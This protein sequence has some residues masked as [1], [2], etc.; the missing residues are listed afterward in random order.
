MIE[1]RCGED[2]TGRMF[3]W[4]TVLA[5]DTSGAGRARWVCRCKCG[6][7]K[8][9][10]AKDMK[11]GKTKSCGCWIRANNP[12]RTHGHSHTRLYSI[13]QGMMRRCHDETNAGYGDYG[14]RGIAV[15]E[16][17]HDV[18]NFHAD[19]GAPPPKHE[20]ERLDNDKGYSPENCKWATRKEQLRN[21]R[22]NLIVEF[23]GQRKCVTDW[24]GGD[25]KTIKR[26]TY[27]LQHGYSAE[28]AITLPA[29]GRGGRQPAKGP[30]V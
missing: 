5:R 12:R 13:W 20:I 28:D 4:L 21:K 6:A 29:L 24:G 30:E 7:I 2:L 15:C 10:P 17:W 14:G 8:S 16:R 23:A 9:V 1:V 26:I 25:R 18:S 19:M 22:N 11:A 27:R 3:T